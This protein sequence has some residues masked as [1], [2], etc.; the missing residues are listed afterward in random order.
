[1]SEKKRDFVGLPTSVELV[2]LGWPSRCKRTKTFIIGLCYGALGAGGYVLQM[3]A[4]KLAAPALPV[5][6]ATALCPQAK[7]ITPVKHKARTIEWLSGA[8]GV[9]Y[10]LCSSLGL[11]PFL[12]TR[13]EPSRTMTWS[14]W[15]A[16]P[17]GTLLDHS[18]SICRKPSPL[19]MWSYTSVSSFWTFQLVSGH[20]TLSLN[21][22]Y[23][24]GLVHV[25][26]GSDE[27]LRLVLFAAHQGRLLHP[28]IKTRVKCLPMNVIPV[29]PDTVDERKYPPYPSTTVRCLSITVTWVLTHDNLPQESGSGDVAVPTTR[30][31]SS[32]YCWFYPPRDIYHYSNGYFRA[33]I[34]NVISAG[35][36]LTRKVVLAF[37]FDEE[38]SIH[39][40]R[41]D[42]TLLL[43]G[44]WGNFEVPTLNLWRTGVRVHRRRGWYDCHRL[45]FSR[46]PNNATFMGG[47]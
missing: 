34:E 39:S 21:K 31:D 47:F 1:M 46:H 43:T 38:A 41:N 30:A 5:Q 37:G 24:W 2:R 36:K 10:V 22:V 42:C 29:N 35:F 17:A 33:A 18:T 16:I 32:E 9:S 11:S 15:A 7:P 45:T 23:T 27:S 6:A 20:S 12:M 3:I 26:Q 13:P 19:C 28:F 8:V 25:W 40:P 4:P 14:L 44:R